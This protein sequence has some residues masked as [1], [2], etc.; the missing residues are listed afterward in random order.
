MDVYLCIYKRNGEL[1][2]YCDPLFRVV[3]NGPCQFLILNMVKDPNRKWQK[4]LFFKRDERTA[5]GVSQEVQ[6]QA[7]E[8]FDE[9][10]I[11]V[12]LFLDDISADEFYHENKSVDVKVVKKDKFLFFKISCE[13]IDDSV[14][15][16]IFTKHTNVSFYKDTEPIDKVTD[17]KIAGLLAAS[18]PYLVKIFFLHHFINERCNVERR[19]EGRKVSNLMDEK[20]E[21]LSVFVGGTSQEEK[22]AKVY[23]DRVV[24]EWDTLKSKR[25]EKS[26]KGIMSGYGKKNEN[27]MFKII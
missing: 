2:T 18:C 23:R 5:D 26:K 4:K 8:A 10:D 19:K 16:K 6:S 20:R 27:D 7:F 15:L 9:S 24:A 12:S 13:K 11:T 22:K 21:T 1:D 14:K 3:R 25:E 17:L